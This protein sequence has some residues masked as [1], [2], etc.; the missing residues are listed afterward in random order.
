[1][2]IQISHRVPIAIFC[3]AIALIGLSCRDILPPKGVG[4]EVQVDSTQAT[5]T[6]N[7][8]HRVDKLIMLGSGLWFIA[9]EGGLTPPVTYREVPLGAQELEP[10]PEAFDPSLQYYSVALI[11]SDRDGDHLVAEGAVG[12][13]PIELPTLEGESFIYAP[14]VQLLVPPEPGRPDIVQFAGLAAVPNSRWKHLSDDAEVEALLNV[15]PVIVSELFRDADGIL[16]IAEYDNLRVAE[17]DVDGETVLFVWDQV[18][19]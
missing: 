7:Q 14:R 13:D 6:W 1:M 3:G 16:Q 8:N 17:T 15:R 18:T 19:P 10:V 9:N 5:V 11:R 2:K 4:L 12:G